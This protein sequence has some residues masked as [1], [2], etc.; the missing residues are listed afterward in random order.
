M[1]SVLVPRPMTARIGGQPLRDVAVLAWASELIEAV[2][3][4]SVAAA[5]AAGTR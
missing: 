4:N 2:L 1:N 5:A 3:L